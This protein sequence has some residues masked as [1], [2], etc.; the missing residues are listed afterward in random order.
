MIINQIEIFNIADLLKTIIFRVQL[1]LFHA[2]RL[3]DAINHTKRGYINRQSI[4]TIQV[5]REYSY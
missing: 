1:L 2:L 4:D 3:A 5:R